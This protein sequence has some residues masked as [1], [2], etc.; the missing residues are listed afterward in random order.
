MSVHRLKTIDRA[1][2]WKVKRAKPYGGKRQALTQDELDRLFAAL[3]GNRHGHRDYMIAL[4]TFLHGLRVSEL[5]D[6]RWDDVDLRKGTIA[7]RRLKGSI[8]GTHYLERDEAI[9]LKRLQR[10]QEPKR[11]H[12]FTSERGQAFS[13]FAINKMIAHRRA[14]RQ[15][16]LAGASALP[17]AHHRHDAGQRRHGCL[18]I[19][20][21]DGPRLDRQHHQIRQDEP[22]AVEGRLEGQTLMGSLRH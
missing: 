4:V 6:L 10:E 15:D 18:A 3:K 11:P 21:A 1:V 8:D 16:H 13:R 14:E 17:P 5:I 20:Q 19:E 2:K 22:G 7:I 12:I 9:G